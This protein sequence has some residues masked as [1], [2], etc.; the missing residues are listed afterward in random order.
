MSEGCSP[1][2]YRDCGL[3]AEIKRLQATNP[4]RANVPMAI[5]LS[6]K[7][8]AYGN[9]EEIALLQTK[10]TQLAAWQKIAI[11]ERAEV[12]RIRRHNKPAET[13]WLDEAAKELDLQGYTFKTAYE[14]DG[15]IEINGERYVNESEQ[16]A[17]V[18]RLE[19]AYV[20]MVFNAVGSDEEAHAALEKIRKG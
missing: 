11:D 6:D 16:K 18:E 15:P 17:Y 1:E 8:F 20:D 13:N 14:P 5:R 19:S 12:L 10:L 2:A 3:R 7:L 4:F 9:D